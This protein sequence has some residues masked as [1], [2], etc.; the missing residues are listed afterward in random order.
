MNHVRISLDRHATT[1]QHVRLVN[2]HNAVWGIQV[3]SGRFLVAESASGRR[4]TPSHHAIQIFEVE[5]SKN[6]ILGDI[7]VFI[8]AT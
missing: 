4:I 8:F 5:V 2:V 6:G 7:H 3:I 1:Y